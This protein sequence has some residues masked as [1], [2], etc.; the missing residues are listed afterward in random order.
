MII[1]VAARDN[2]DVTFDVLMSSIIR[3]DRASR[4]V[5]IK[6]REAAEEHPVT[7]PRMM[8]SIFAYSIAIN[9]VINTTLI[10]IS[11]R[12]ISARRNSV[13]N[14]NDTLSYVIKVAQTFFTL[15]F[16]F[17]QL[18]R[19]YLKCFKINDVTISWQK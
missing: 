19:R 5:T 14:C 7:T 4:G 3:E 16:F 17:P 2:F 11:R 15:G 10:G 1:S 6:R 18:Q 9:I 13:I 12:Y 8:E